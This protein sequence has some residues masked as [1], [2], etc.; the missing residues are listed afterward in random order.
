MPTC[1]RV[2]GTKGCARAGVGR[3]M[4]TDT[5][6]RTVKQ[7]RAVHELHKKDK[8]RIAMTVQWRIKGD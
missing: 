3:G 4:S 6:Y 8:V 1:L 7:Q 5:E 2:D